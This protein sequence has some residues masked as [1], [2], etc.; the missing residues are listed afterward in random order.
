MHPAPT[1][2]M[3]SRGDLRLLLSAPGGGPGGGAAMPDGTLPEPGGWNR[4]QLEVAHLE[5]PSRSC[6][7]AGAPFATRSSPASAV[8]QIWSRTRRA[9]RS[10]CSSPRV[11]RLRCRVRTEGQPDASASVPC[12]F[13]NA[14]AA[15]SSSGRANRKPW[16]RSQCWR[17]SARSCSLVLDALAER[18]EVERLAELHERVDQRRGL[19]A[20]RRSPEMNERS[21]FS[22]STGNWRR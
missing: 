17:C 12:A 6:A 16:P 5:S 8:K 20:T 1:F 9:T 14:S 22:A 4:F 7:A 3:L 21:I 2:A 13:R 18:L 15:S 19:A 10:S 11:P